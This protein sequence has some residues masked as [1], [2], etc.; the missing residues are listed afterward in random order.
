MHRGLSRFDPRDAQ[1]IFDHLESAGVIR[2]VLV[3][4]AP[5]SPGRGRAD[6]VAYELLRVEPEVSGGTRGRFGALCSRGG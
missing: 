1:A 2:R 5:Y 6:L 3:A 4:A